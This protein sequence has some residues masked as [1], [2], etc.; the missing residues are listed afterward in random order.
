MS[1]E[2]ET[3]AAAPAAPPAAVAP[4]TANPALLGLI[5]FLPAGITLGL[6]FVGYLDTTALPGGMIPALT[7]SAGLFMMIA[8]ISALR[9]GDSVSAAIF[10]VF[11]AFWTSFGVLLMA[12]NNGWI[13][14][15]GTGEALSTAQIGSIQST[16][17][18][19]FTL[20]FILLTLATLRLP[21]MFTI[22]FVL[23]DI[24]FVL[25]YLGV[26]AGNAGLFPIAGITTFAFCAVFAY[27][28]FDAF[29][30]TLGGRAMAMGNPLVRS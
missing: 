4:P 9:V 5:C 2:S 8:A 30:Q 24:T 28:L 17:L 12:L 26:T 15:A 29:G 3:A 7:F 13:I 19:S 23:V 25:A 1:V 10:G 27:I 11:S 22:G 6:W 16:Y 14:D 21:L 20:V 18:L